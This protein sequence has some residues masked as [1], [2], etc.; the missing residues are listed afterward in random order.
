TIVEKMTMLDASAALLDSG[1]ITDEALMYV[2]G[3]KIYLAHAAVKEALLRFAPKIIDAL[4]GVGL[5]L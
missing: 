2:A 5:V 1:E 3:L 4:V